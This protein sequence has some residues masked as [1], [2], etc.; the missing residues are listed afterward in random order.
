MDLFIPSRRHTGTCPTLIPNLYNISM[1]GG[2]GRAATVSRRRCPEPISGEE[3]KSSEE[4]KGKTII[5][6][7]K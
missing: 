5:S 3:E 4:G 2:E 6:N 7:V 1:K